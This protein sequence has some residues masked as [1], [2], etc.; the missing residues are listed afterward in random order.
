MSGVI[1]CEQLSFDE[2]ADNAGDDFEQAWGGS[3]STCD[4]IGCNSDSSCVGD[5]DGDFSVS[6]NDIITLL[7]AWGSHDD[8]ADLDQSG[9]VGLSDLLV[10]LGHWGPCP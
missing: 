10:L 6:V 5:I 1:V 7:G 9:T 4:D 2:C 8:S 3:N